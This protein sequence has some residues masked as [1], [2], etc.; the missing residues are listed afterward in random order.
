[1]TRDILAHTISLLD[2]ICRTSP[3]DAMRVAVYVRQYMA[4]L[5]ARGALDDDD[6]RSFEAVLR[7]WH[8]AYGLPWVCDATAAFALL[9]PN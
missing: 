5:V 2:R 8:E 6:Y 1:M 3:T 9:F 4:E 7:Q